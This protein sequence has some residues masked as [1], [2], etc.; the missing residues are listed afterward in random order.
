MIDRNG[1]GMEEG[2]EIGHGLQS[3]TRHVRPFFREETSTFYVDSSGY[4]DSKGIETDIATSICIRYVAQRA[5]RLRFVVLINAFQFYSDRAS[6]LKRN[7]DV[8]AK[9]IGHNFEDHK[10]SFTFFF[11]HCNEAFSNVR[12]VI[13]DSSDAATTL[14]AMREEVLRLLETTKKATTD[15]S[16]LG[17]I[18]F[19]RGSMKKSYP[20]CDVFD[21][22]YSDIEKIRKDVEP[23][24]A[25]D[26]ITEP[27]KVVECC[28]TEP[29]KVVECSLTPTARM[30]VDHEVEERMASISRSLSEGA[31]DDTLHQDVR[32]ITLLV[33]HIGSLGNNIRDR[34][35]RDLAAAS[36]RM[37][38]DLFRIVERGTLSASE[39]GSP[40]TVDEA[41]LANKLITDGSFIEKLLGRETDDDAFSHLVSLLREQAIWIKKE[42][43]KIELFLEGKGGQVDW[44]K[45]SA[46]FT[47]L[48]VWAEVVS[49]DVESLYSGVQISTRKSLESLCDEVFLISS[50]EHERRPK[51]GQLILRAVAVF[52]AATL[53]GFV[54]QCLETDSVKVWEHA[55][56]AS[57]KA[58]KSMVRETEKTAQTVI[59]NAFN[60]LSSGK[61][62]EDCNNEINSELL[63]V[64]RNADMMQDII[65]CEGIRSRLAG[66][67]IRRVVLIIALAEFLQRVEV[68]SKLLQASGFNVGSTA[69]LCVASL[70]VFVNSLPNSIKSAGSFISHLDSLQ[71][72]LET[73]IRQV[74]DSVK[75]AEVHLESNVMVGRLDKHSVVLTELKSFAWVDGQARK[76]R[77]FPSIASAVQGAQA[78]YLAYAKRLAT[79]CDLALVMALENSEQTEI[80]TKKA[81]ESAD[82]FRMLAGMTV[83]IPTTVMDIERLELRVLAWVGKISKRVDQMPRLKSTGSDLILLDSVLLVGKALKQFGGKVKE[84][85]V[86]LLEAVHTK[87][88]S[89]RGEIGT[90]FDDPTAFARQQELVESAKQ[91]IQ[92]QGARQRL[93][94]PDTLVKVVHNRFVKLAEALHQQ[95]KEPSENIHMEDIDDQF[96]YLEEAGTHFDYHLDGVCSTLVAGLY[97]SI[98]ARKADLDTRFEQHLENNDFEALYLYVADLDKPGLK[99]KH[100]QCLRVVSSRLWA[101]AESVRKDI[102]LPANTASKRDV[103]KTMNKLKTLEDS[104]MHLGPIGPFPPPYEGGESWQLDGVAASL[105]LEAAV[106]LESTLGLVAKAVDATD[107]A[108][109]V[110]GMDHC[111][112]LLQVGGDIHKSKVMDQQADVEGFFTRFEASVGLFLRSLSEGSDT[113]N[114]R[115][116]NKNHNPTGIW[117]P[118]DTSFL[119]ACLSSLQHSASLPGC[120]ERISKVYASCKERMSRSI[121]DLWTSLQAECSGGQFTRSV[122]L[123]GFLRQELLSF[124][125][126]EHVSLDF[127]IS[128]AVDLVASQKDEHEKA[129]R[130]AALD[131]NEID[132][133]AADLDR[134]SNLWFDVFG[135]QD[136]VNSQRVVSKWADSETRRAVA[137]IDN[138]E[139]YR[140]RVN[141]SELAYARSKL[142]KHM[143]FR[144]NLEEVLVPAFSA[145]LSDMLA[146]MGTA[147]RSHNYDHIQQVVFPPL[148]GLME[149]VCLNRSTTQERKGLL[150]E[151]DKTSFKFQHKVHKILCAHVQKL[152]ELFNDNLPSF[153]FKLSDVAEKL[154]GCGCFFITSFSLYSQTCSPVVEDQNFRHL[155]ALVH[156]LFGGGRVSRI[157]ACFAALEVSPSSSPAEI[158][159]AYKRLSR[160]NHPDKN[161]G[162]ERATLK[163]AQLNEANEV[164][165]DDRNVQI[166]RSYDFPFLVNAVRGICGRLCAHVRSSLQAREYS[167]VRSSLENIETVS[168]LGTLMKTPSSVDTAKLKADLVKLAKGHANKIVVEVQQAHGNQNFVEL[169]HS[170][171]DLESFEKEFKSFNEILDK[172]LASSLKDQLASN[173]ESLKVAAMFLCGQSENRA[174]KEMEEFGNRLIKLGHFHD[175]FPRLKKNTTAAIHS[176]LNAIQT[177]P[178]GM[179]F[180]FKLG[181]LLEKGE[182]SGDEEDKRIGRVIVGSFPHFQDV[183]T[184]VFNEEVVT[185]DTEDSVKN[186]TT[187]RYDGSSVLKH[188]PFDHVSLKTE[189]DRYESLFSKHFENFV[190]DGHDELVQH[191][192]ATVQDLGVCS[193]GNWNN[194]VKTKITEILAGVFATFTIIRSGECFRRFKESS[195]ED[196]SNTSTDAKTLLFR[197]HSIQ[198]IAI[199]RLLGIGSSGHFLPNHIMEVRT[200]EGKSIILGALAT[201]LALLG[202]RVKCV[203]YSE[204]LSERDNEL[205]KDVF[206]TFGI[207]D[208]VKYSKITT[209]S[210]DSVAERGN[211]RQLTLDLVNGTLDLVNGDL[212][213]TPRSTRSAPF[214]KKESNKEEVHYEGKRKLG[215]ISNIW[216]ASKPSRKPSGE[217][218]E[219]VSYDS[220]SDAEPTN[221]SSCNGSRSSALHLPLALNDEE[222]L[223]VDEVDVFFGPDFYGKTYNQVAE[224]SDPSITKLMTKIWD[225]RKTKPS[226]SAVKQWS[227]YATVLQ[228]FSNWPL[229]I[230]T[231]VR[232]M[233]GDVQSFSEPAYEV[234][235]VNCRVGYRHMDSVDWDQTFG[236]RTAFAHVFEKE[237]GTLSGA[238]ADKA[239]AQ[240]LSLRLACG[241]FSYAAINPTAILGVSGTLS[242]MTADEQSIVK[243]LGVDTYSFVP[244]VYGLNKLTFDRAGRGI[245]I[246]N[247]RKRYLQE[248]ANTMQQALNEGRSAIA[249]F[250]TDERLLEFKKSSHWRQFR[251]GN[252]LL[253]TTEKE[254]RKYIINKAATSQQVTISTAIFGRG[255][256]FF[257]KDTKLESNGGMVVVQTFL[258]VE[259]S[260]ELQ[261]QGR[262]GRQGKKGSYCM[263]LLEADLVDKFGISP[264]QWTMVARKDLYDFLDSPRQRVHSKALR[265][266]KEMVNQAEDRDSISR[267]YFDALIAGDNHRATGAWNNIYE[268][269]KNDSK[270]LNFCRMVCCLDATV[271]MEPIWEATKQCIH[272]MLKRI[273]DLGEGQFE[274]MFVAYRDYTE[275]KKGCRPLLEKS[276]WSKN[277][278]D[279][280][281][282]VSS[283]ETGWGMPDWAKAV[284]HALEFANEEHAHDPITRVIVIGDSPPHFERKGEALP[285]HDNRLLT[286]DYLIETERLRLN[287]IPTYTFR[288]NDDPKLVDMFGHIAN[289]SGGECHLLDIQNSGSNKLIDYVCETALEDIGGS[290]LVAEY[291][292]RHGSG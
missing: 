166:F 96:R 204:H 65:Q 171:T 189:C 221:R 175:G 102:P 56:K 106:V 244:S 288:L 114:S 1:D 178:W 58:A 249:F 72:E 122:K 3:M 4:G 81:E 57:I 36:G 70:H 208:R 76:S 262:T 251:N 129:F 179:S 22:T 59:I 97:Q 103:A 116:M 276:S 94:P 202:F 150:Y 91:W 281:D 287:G 40:F 54:C 46:Q 159:Q 156:G 148:L 212:K 99:T 126:K 285:A 121:N 104:E 50:D 119:R 137:M 290:D 92:L 246:E 26:S 167:L 101:V 191:V 18:K 194:A 222:I 265:Q 87:L 128:T 239:V 66:L 6:E 268:I 273:D 77:D 231:E 206:A 30:R 24:S 176:T 111:A 68:C 223:L 154:Q 255:T 209:M 64:L 230:E 291:R 62:G 133:I 181:L 86:Q 213:P 34:L 155:M 160:L 266:T 37:K 177:E 261:V 123:L 163:S 113:Q 142:G 135:N 201:V 43:S 105:R 11:T 88:D 225:S 180:T 234:D 218:S 146:D 152:S 185:A 252:I 41:L 173:I 227:E 145:R 134:K 199:L 196:A 45:V 63:A 193:V 235:R 120:H 190:Q 19:L 183:R 214:P 195:E 21:P 12:S 224:L 229:Q 25:G 187:K 7:L 158:S 67:D 250:E 16:T 161:P 286:T 144:W 136:Y 127:D 151:F 198:I 264:G 207:V 157:G 2:F 20:F 108:C 51:D 242:A 32:S 110:V 8:V 164:L 60:S 44:N 139:F 149:S 269:V 5:A 125:L 55:N 278:Q 168:E 61:Q 90:I 47:S 73:R 162:N 75:A 245:T 197:P 248:V 238:L 85:V 28:I 109:S 138:T 118:P 186:T 10:L 38:S 226:F 13:Q 211:I 228:Q 52:K 95:V 165:S 9:F 35:K 42:V 115:G 210:E 237:Q 39:E 277:P 141:V 170:F 192:L 200:G 205:F 282:F 31:I 74:L 279:L 131:K 172:S 182:L 233:C 69:R 283:I 33:E 98:E 140:L 71:R 284:E 243:D 215:F 174:N 258:S 272:E 217:T 253:S 257:C 275:H 236:Y 216:K 270:S 48:R 79:N 124:G 27:A 247:D 241:Q 184:A 143:N 23:R 82:L 219:L 14:S 78:A 100:H 289:E 271:S 188:T 132:R 107:F 256:D 240:A 232:K 203:C 274:L 259:K 117:S 254:T 80:R 169:H 147:L 130:N 220:G 112:F 53:S 260:E 89:L 29:A 280:S 263:V 153:T 93:P 49:G 83:L 292:A 267:S 84:T 15:H 17:L